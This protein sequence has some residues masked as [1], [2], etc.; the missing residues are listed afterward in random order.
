VII[1]PNACSGTLV[2]E[3]ADKLK[4]VVKDKFAVELEI[5]PRIIR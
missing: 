2:L 4:Q 1:N 5:E 3:Y